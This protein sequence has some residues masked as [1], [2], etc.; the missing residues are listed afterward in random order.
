MPGTGKGHQPVAER[1]T[2]SIRDAQPDDGA[3]VAVLLAELGYADNQTLGVR[4]RLELWAAEATSRALVAE[5]DGQVLGIIA[6]TAIP[7][8]EREGRWGRIVAL[9]VSSAC[10]GQGVGRLLVEAAENAA[11]DL[12][13]IAM[14]VTS[15][16]SRTDSHP[17]YQILGYQDWGQRLLAA[18]HLSRATGLCAQA[19]QP[20]KP[21]VR[22]GTTTAADRRQNV[23]TPQINPPYR[24][25]IRG[26]G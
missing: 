10:R 9:V 15:A 6:V 5:L 22:T 25:L 8:L 11:S 20:R 23:G 24:A 17:F 14:E 7:Y 2:C 26:C 18:R 21:T 13:C 4:R 1:T 16:R 19:G 3:Q 12:G